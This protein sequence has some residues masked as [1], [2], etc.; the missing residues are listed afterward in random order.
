MVTFKSDHE[1]FEIFEFFWNFGI[2]LNFLK[3][4]KLFIFFT[5]S[6]SSCLFI[7]LIKCLK[8]H[9]SLGSL[10]NVWLL[11]VTDQGTRCPIELLWTA[12]KHYSQGPAQWP[13]GLLLR[14]AVRASA[15]NPFASRDPPYMGEGPC[16]WSA[17]A[18]VP[19]VSDQLDH[20]VH[21]AKLN[22]ST[23]F[24]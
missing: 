12:K 13:G 8:G 16:A 22:S 18:N 10:C 7:T 20:M 9:K 3:S 4:L 2:F 14:S 24:W 15:R 21:M 19:R 23:Y 17:E 6:V 11:V 1:F 5:I